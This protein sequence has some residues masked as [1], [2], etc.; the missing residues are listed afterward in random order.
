MRHPLRA[1]C[2]GL[3]ST[4]GLSLAVPA[5]AAP[6]MIYVTVENLAPM[7]SVAVAPLGFAWHAGSHDP[8]NV[9]MAPSAAIATL[10]ELGAVSDFLAG[11]LAADAT[12]VTGSTGAPLLPGGT[13]MT[14]QFAIDTVANAY[15]SFGAMVVPSNDSFIGNDDPMAYRLFDMDGNLAIHQINLTASDVWDAGSEAF[16]IPNAAFIVGSDATQ[17]IAE[18]GVV[19]S[20][21]A[22]FALFNGLPTAGGYMFDS[23]LLADT[24]IYR[25]SFSVANAVP[26]PASWA[27]MI[28]GFGL[29]GGLLRR[30]PA[31]AQFA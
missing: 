12:A 22:N 11:F 6:V 28:A 14:M 31:R 17:R 2:L 9:G 19:T 1:A 27:L 25:I 23:A 13:E 5:M 30:R 26:E 4:A 15:F 16:S 29:A 8:F 7:T 18:G 21:F 3:A 10:A 24:A 20:T